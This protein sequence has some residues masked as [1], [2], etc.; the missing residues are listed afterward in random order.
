MLVRADVFDDVAAILLPRDAKHLDKH[1]LEYN[2]AVLLGALQAT[3]LS[4]KK[5]SAQAGATAGRRQVD[6]TGHDVLVSLAAASVTAFL[7]GGS[8]ILSARYSGVQS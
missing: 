3:L 8:T 7:T 4:V 1:V 6:W 2:T 5:I